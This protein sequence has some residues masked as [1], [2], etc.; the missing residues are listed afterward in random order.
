MKK[1]ISWLAILL[2]SVASFALIMVARAATL[3][4][5]TSLQA[6]TTI[7]PVS[8]TSATTIVPV[9]IATPIA[10]KAGSTINF[11]GQELER[12]ESPEQLKEFR[13]MR[14]IGHTLYGI[15]LHINREINR[16]GHALGENN[17][18]SALSSKT[19][20]NYSQE[21][22]KIDSPEQLKEFKVMKRIGHTLYGIRLSVLRQL[23]QQMRNNSQP[24]S[25]SA[26]QISATSSNKL[27]KI[28]APGLIHLYERIR[29]IGHSLWGMRKGIES[30][31][32]NRRSGEEENNSSRVKNESNQEHANFIP[33]TANMAA[34]VASA[35]SIKDQAVIARV[36][37][38]AS[39]LETAITSRG[40]CQLAA[41]QSTSNQQAALASCVK[42]FQTTR[43]QINKIAQQA[44]KEAWTTFRGSL[45]TCRQKVSTS[46]TTSI[47]T[48]SSATPSTGQFIIGDGG[49]N[50]TSSV[51]DNG[52]DN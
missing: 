52:G 3:I 16:E 26:G 14:R 10:V 15:R 29:R 4:P 17:S 38:A 8:T 42:D 21:L 18:G 40:V 11:R 37:S 39:S 32:M 45:Q 50:I 46:A 19:T 9:K 47:S 30:K 22:E 35:I 34:C 6:T 20:N 23:K 5:T 24:N 7:A 44:Q 49:T 2:V 48:P 27:E 13:V 36:S 1:T 41:I 12:I 43:A 33:V 51:L 28:A 31:N 25:N